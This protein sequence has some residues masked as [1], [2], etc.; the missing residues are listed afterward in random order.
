MRE[1][2]AEILN[3]DGSTGFSTKIRQPYWNDFITEM[4]DKG[5]LTRLF[6]KYMTQEF[7]KVGI[8]ITRSII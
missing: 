5:G 8:Q 6:D 2:L 4:F 1:K 7:G 3:V